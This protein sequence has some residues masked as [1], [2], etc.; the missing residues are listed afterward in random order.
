VYIDYS[1][2]HTNG[3]AADIAESA[4]AAIEFRARSVVDRF[5]QRRVQAMAEIPEA[6]KRLMV[7]LCNI[8]SVGGSTSALSPAVASFSND[9][10]S[11]SYAAPMTP[12]TIQRT[13]ESLVRTYLS[14]VCDDNGT[15][16]LW[17]GVN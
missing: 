3:G 17:A 6:V 9:G 14:S 15:P 5:T 1:Y 11:E 8:E 2:F 4:F 7:E 12:E 10:Y 13:E 16:L